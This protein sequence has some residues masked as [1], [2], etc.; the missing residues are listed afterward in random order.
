MKELLRRVQARPLVAVEMAFGSL[1]VN[2]L[3][4]ASPLFVMQI[5]NRYVGQG[6]DATLFTLTSGVLIAIGFE[7]ALR[8][9]RLSLARGISV[10]PDEAIA[11]RA[12]D[13]LT[14]AKV[15]ALDQTPAETRKEIVNGTTAIEA[16]YNATNITTVLDAPFSLLFIFVLYIV[17]PMLAGV[18]LLFV[19]GVYAIGLYGHHKLQSITLELQQVSG[20]GGGLLSTATREA[21]M[22]RSFNAGDFIRQRWYG[23]ITHAQK[24]RRDLNATQGL[25][26]TLTGSAMAL[27][28]VCVI[29]IGAVLVVSGKLDVGAMIGGN[30]L[31]A[32]A[33]Q[34]VTRLAQLGSAFARARQSKAVFDQL[35]AIEREATAGATVSAYSGKLEFRDAAF[36]YPGSKLPI[37]ESLNLT[38]GPGDVLVVLGNNGTG[39]STFA[40]LLLGLIEPVRG[41]ILV[42]GL[43]MKQLAPDWWR[44]QVVYLPQEPALLNATIRENLTVN[45]RD[46]DDAGLAAIVE[47]CGLKRYLD[48]SPDGLDAMIRDNG[49]RLS[50]GIRRRIALGRALATDGQLVIIDEPTESLDDEGCKAVYRVLA[51]MA[52]QKRTIV[53]MSHDKD[54]VKGSHLRLD[55][56]FK[57]VPRLE[58]FGT[59]LLAKPVQQIEG[60]DKPNESD[61]GAAS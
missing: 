32:R 24:L 33:L 48:E 30:I 58:K 49:W 21:D 8:R 17:E 42:D 31:A 2:V 29:G 50:E 43:D 55:L 20:E 38:V 1:L 13:T 54:I 23:H 22:I 16:A 34:P 6:V 44:R 12:F 45:N 60:P 3:A 7:F 14:S 37:F 10:G 57:P 9:S 59:K 5:L 51:S 4:M 26:Q 61:K 52:D 11:L 39:K 53:V 47:K 35:D 19:I 40:R 15:P 56:N 41:Q 25:V 36:S 46:L 27:L 18:T 28:S